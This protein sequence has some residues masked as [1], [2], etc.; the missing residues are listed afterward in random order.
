MTWRREGSWLAA[1]RGLIPIPAAQNLPVPGIYFT[2]KIIF[3]VLQGERRGGSVKNVDLSRSI[4]I[5]PAPPKSSTSR[6]FAVTPNRHRQTAGRSGVRQLQSALR[7]H[8]AVS[9]IGRD[10]ILLSALSGFSRKSRLEKTT[11][12]VHCRDQRPRR[13]VVP[14]H[15]TGRISANGG[16]AI[17]PKRARGLLGRP[18]L[19][20][21]SGRALAATPQL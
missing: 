4:V 16:G 13:W 15:F 5:F 9:S 17:S 12:G 2:R 20:Q 8:S 21:I 7:K 3:T 10:K 14:D 6:V 1:L 19:L 11:E 18:Q